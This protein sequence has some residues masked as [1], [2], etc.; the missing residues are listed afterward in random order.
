M[1]S[2]ETPVIKQFKLQK[3]PGSVS[4]MAVP[5]MPLTMSLERTLVESGELR[6]ATA[7]GG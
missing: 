6:L 7:T 4:G 5:N 1:W 2:L 3:R